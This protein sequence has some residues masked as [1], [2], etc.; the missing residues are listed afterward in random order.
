MALSF[1]LTQ[2]GGIILWPEHNVVKYIS[3]LLI[4]HTCMC[5]MTADRVD[6]KK[7]IVSL[8]TFFNIRARLSC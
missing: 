6:N 7:N 8:I 2:Q 4:S 1:L 5:T 3:L